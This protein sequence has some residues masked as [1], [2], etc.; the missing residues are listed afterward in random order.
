MRIEMKEIRGLALAEFDGLGQ[1]PPVHNARPMSDAKAAILPAFRNIM[2]LSPACHST[3]RLGETSGPVIT[4]TPQI[5]SSAD[6][7]SRTGYAC[8]AP[9]V[10][11]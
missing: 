2:I 1:L 11:A 7:E 6:V 5:D 3:Y 9:T 10:W 8:V 4:L